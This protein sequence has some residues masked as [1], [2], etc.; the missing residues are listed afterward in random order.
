MR[1]AIVILNWNGKDLLERFLPSVVAHADEAELWVID[2]ASTDDSIKF[3][4]QNFPSVNRILLNQNYGFAKGYNDGLKKIDADLFCLLNNDVAPNKNWI[5]P[6]KKVFETSETAI[7]QPKI[8]NLKHPNTFDYAGAAGGFIDRYG[9]PYC[10]GRIFD[11]L[12]ED[13]NQYTSSSCFWASGACLFIRAKVWHELGGFDEDFFMHQE[14]IDLCWRAFNK[15]HKVK[16]ITEASVDHLGAASLKPSPKKTYL[17]HRNSLWMLIKNLPKSQLIPVTLS[18]M[19]LDGFAGIRYLIQGN[20]RSFFM[21]LR[22]HVHLYLNL[23]KML[24]KRSTAGQRGDYFHVRNLPWQYFIL[25]KRKF[26]Q[27]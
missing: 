21:V 16:C 23:N 20:F 5:S 17:N 7:A 4:E 6:I 14:E 8:L 25:R 19:V 27:F 18:R 9:Y 13:Q 3:L 1:L 26:S 15:G 22:A 10:R 11:N 2:N 12:E 24:K